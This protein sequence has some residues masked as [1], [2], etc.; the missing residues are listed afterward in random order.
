MSCLN[1]FPITSQFLGFIHWMVFRLI[2]Y[3]CVTVQ[4]KNTSSRPL[5]QCVFANLI[6]YKKNFFSQL[7]Q[8]HQIIARFLLGNL[9]Q[10]LFLQPIHEIHYDD[11]SVWTEEKSNT[12][13]V[14]KSWS[15]YRHLKLPFRSWNCLHSSYRV[16]AC[17]YWMCWNY[18]YTNWD[19]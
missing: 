18:L 10:I 15:K 1:L 4:T 7:R 6:S 5:G 2:C 9:F 19:V 13:A 17:L 16:V 11:T 14:S 8:C 3:N 12:F